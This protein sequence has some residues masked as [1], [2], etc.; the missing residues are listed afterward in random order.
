[1]GPMQTASIH[2]TAEAAAL[3]RLLEQG[4]GTVHMVGIGGV[5]MAGLSVLLR[6]RGLVVSGCDTAEGPFTEWLR[7]KGIEVV[8]GHSAEHVTPSVAAVIRTAAVAPDSPEIAAARDRAVPVLRRG[9]VLPCLLSGRTSI[10]VSGT[11]GK[12]TTSA[13]IAQMLSLAGRGPSWCIGGDVRRLGGVAGTGDGAEIV[14]EADESDATVALYHPDIAV[15]T[16]VEFDHMEHFDSVETFEACF[17]QFVMQT[18]RC[19]VYCAD[20]PRAARIACRAERSLSYGLDAAADIRAVDIVR[21]GAGASFVLQSGVRSAGPCRLNLPGQ[22]NV[23]NVV[24]AV[25]VLLELGIDLDEVP[26]LLPGLALPARRFERVASFAGGGV[27]S[28]YAHHPSEIAALVEAA[29]SVHP[30]RLRA[31]F[32]PHR[33]TRTLALGAGFPP[34]FAGVDEVVLVPVYPASEQPLEGGTIGYLYAH[35]RQAQDAGKTSPAV[36]L[37][38]DLDEVWPY[39]RETLR[40]GDLLLVVGAGDVEQVAGQAAEAGFL[41]QSEPAGRTDAWCASL[42]ARLSGSAVTARQ[43]LGR[44]TSLR[45]GGAAD[46]WVDVE[47]EADLCELMAWSRVEGVPV[48]TLGAGFNVLASDLG[49]RGVVAR[50]SGDEFR[51]LRAVD[52]VLEAGGGVPL[53]RVVDWAEDHVFRGFEFLHGIPGS[54]GGAARMNAG[55]WGEELCGILRWIRCLNRDG[56]ISIVRVEDLG[57]VYR[58]CR[59]LEEAVL[60]SAGFKLVQG[61]AGQIRARRAE[62][63][64]KREWMTGLHSAGSVFRNPPGD[65]AG[66]LLEAAGLKGA[67]VGGAEVSSYKANVL[68]TVDGA[69]ASDVAALMDMMRSRVVIQA[70]TDLNREVKWLS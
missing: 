46:V 13:F 58:N 43:P 53:A 36:A 9:Q 30:G 4:A 31:V 51:R 19:V 42:R 70:G 25:A 11:H 62:I 66:R 28:D 3:M 1:M 38:R 17:E 24:G 63:G 8:M 59:A 48:R 7:A 49:V 14:I 68:F 41:P 65:Y 32:Q 5:G 21:D 45:V 27:V 57:M 26:G 69:T 54:V 50:L 47:N 39:F 40:D 44:K 34:A 64:Q 37:A 22:H 60:L 29:K 55:A 20:D 23:R 61:E 12:T 15:V 67:H 16:N 10:A 18:G 33:Y 56:S 6:E 2:D 35:F 52:G